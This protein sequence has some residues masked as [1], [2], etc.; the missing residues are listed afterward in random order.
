MAYIPVPRVD[1]KA[2][3]QE[4]LGD[5]AERKEFRAFMV[6]PTQPGIPEHL[7]GFT[8]GTTQPLYLPGLR[9][10]GVQL[11]VRNFENPDTMYMRLFIDWQT[12]TG[13]TL[14]LAAISHEFIR[15]FRVRASL[16]ED[17]PAVTVIGFTREIIQDELLSHPEL[18]FVSQTEAKD[19]RRMRA[20]A[21]SAG[22][23]SLEARQLSSFLG[24]LRRRT[25]DRNRG[26]YYQFYGYKEFASRLF[27]VTRQGTA[28]KF[29]VQKLYG[30]SEGQF[31]IQLAEAVRRGDV[32]VNED[33]L[34]QLRGGLL[35]ADE[36]HNVYNIS[37]TNNYGIAIQ[38]ALDSLGDNAP[39][40]VFMSA[41]PMTGSAAEI[42][43]LLN[44][45]VP[46]S[47]LPGGAPLRRTDFFIR[48]AAIAD[49]DSLASSTFIVSKLRDGA[50][51]RI[52]MLAA[53]RVSFLLDS[54]VESYPRREF[55]GETI[56][57][58]PYLQMTP[59]PMSKFHMRTLEH[60]QKERTSAESAGFA[61]NAY[62]L[63]DMAFPNPEF[64]PDAA[65]QT[66]GDSYGL[67]KSGET[68]AKLTQASEDWRAAAGV[69]VERGVATGTPIITGNFLSMD[70]LHEYST[71]YAKMA[72]D[73]IDI[74]R[75][76]PGKVLIYHHRVRMS[77]VLLLQ[78]ILRMNGF[79]DELSAPTDATI[80]AVCG[81]AR[82]E[83]GDSHDYTPARFVVAHSDVD[84][85]VMFRSI[86]KFNAAA[87]LDGHQY[88][89]LIGSKIIR[90]GYNFRAVR[91]ELVCS[92]PTD[93]P[94][95][96]QVFGRVV[97]K[98][99]HNELP[100]DERNVRIRVYV[101]TREDGRPSP[102]L[103]RY[104]N[105]GKEY[106]VIQE[107]S[108][109]L[110]VSAIDGFA[111]YERIR[112][113]L[114]GMKHPTLDSL[115]YSPI[116]TPENAASRPVRTATFEAYGHGERE[117]A[118]IAATC[119][120]LFQTRPVWTYPDLWAA[121][122]S[123][124]IRGVN[125][126]PGSFD[127]GNF[128]LAL[129]SLSKP[130]GTPPRMVV[131]AGK[132]FVST[133]AAPDGTPMLDVET[134][135]RAG[136]AP[137]RISVRVAS[138]LRE[139]RSGHNFNVRLKEFER[140]Y[141]LPDAP[142]TP[143]LSLVEYGAAFHYALIRRLITSERN[144]Q[145]TVDDDRVRDLYRRFRLV[146]TLADASTKA[147]SRVFR[148]TRSKKLDK[149]VGYLT[150]DAVS[151]YEPSKN[152]WYSGAHA[153]FSIGRRHKEN[154]IVVGFVVS[155]GGPRSGTG[156]TFASANTEAK[157]KIRP[158]TQKMQ[159]HGHSDI[160]SLARGAVCETRPREELKT[161]AKRLQ[162]AVARSDT[163]AHASRGGSND[164]ATSSGIAA[165]DCN[166]GGSALQLRSNLN[167]A[168]KFDRAA[169]VRFPSAGEVCDTIRLHL[170]ALEE[171]ARSPKNGMTEGLRWLYLYCD[172][173]PS[174][175]ALMGKKP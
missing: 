114:H 44:L 21:A 99:S 167:Y 92:L 50:L 9:L 37:E 11:F 85:A 82:A 83:H 172:R 133:L 66:S 72:A 101:T 86:A 62:T 170:L 106:L 8:E 13:K 113:A 77:G 145:V 98:G 95:M 100:E 71:K 152:L 4:L 105:K 115:P 110:R 74:I 81:I 22:S 69:I 155:M 123:G 79:A 87:N 104:I 42:V 149:I 25:T 175:S 116:I 146:V 60:E 112:T 54:D 174:V 139:S 88:R 35:V 70:H 1:G 162:S 156:E 6:P 171:D 111:N 2:G 141:L 43:D 159:G 12:G 169:R 117:V 38:Y 109:A 161:Y 132:F 154:N 36:I 164:V 144:E 65:S 127:E 93:Y 136:A 63:Y 19:L 151:L 67:Y 10:H 118:T 153:D 7:S 14:A 166:T 29:D 131:R 140:T 108:R 143:E 73:A 64:P 129:T 122:K 173:P 96:I 34:D 157:F 78:E 119:R 75:G 89:V 165:C 20:A 130:T 120:V 134:Y 59:C 107:V 137:A 31:G 128:A 68:P 135:L 80:C 39:R 158:P 148:G 49:E 147:A 46:R 57:G 58:V 48:T 121:V 124:T 91:N 30:R 27:S 32:V 53:G 102:E 126:D 3:I 5:L 23:G 24:V 55:V 52:E 97:R 61:A 45:L 142:S 16:G 47:S 84:H 163:T 18:G 41:T 160:R 125:Y 103:Q 15:Q 17:A 28:H 138:Y 56:A 168:A 40:A 51:K 150:P 76:G 90:E 33:L 26:G 94:T